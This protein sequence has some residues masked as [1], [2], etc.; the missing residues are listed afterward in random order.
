MLGDLLNNDCDYDKVYDEPKEYMFTW[1]VMTILLMH[2]DDDELKE[3]IYTWYMMF[4]ESWWWWT[5]GIYLRVHN[6]W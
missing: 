3:F 6:L 4:I 5:Y 1:F 2:D